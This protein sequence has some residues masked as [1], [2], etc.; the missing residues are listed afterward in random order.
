MTFRT[1]I[2]LTAPVSL[3]LQLYTLPASAQTQ[4][5]S[6]GQAAEQPPIVRFDPQGIGVLEAVMLTLQNDPALKLQ[7]TAVQRAGGLEQ[8]ARGLF[9]PSLLTIA[10]YEYRIQE[11]TENRKE[12][13]R[14]KRENA[15]EQLD[16]NRTNAERGRALVDQLQRVRDSPPGSNQ[17]PLLTQLSPTLGAQVQVIDALIAGTSD[18]AQRATLLDVRNTLLNNSIQQTQSDLA[19]IVEAFDASQRR[20]ENLGEAPIDEVFYSGQLSVQVAKLFRNGISVTP[21]FDGSMQGTN[22]RGKPRSDEF[23]GKGLQDL[24]TFHAGVGIVVPLLQGRGSTAVAARERAAQLDLEASRLALGHERAVSAL[25]AITAY[26]ALRAAQE[27]ADVAARSLALQDRIVAATNARIKAGDMLAV[28]GTRAQATAARARARVEETR[29]QLHEARVRLASAMGVAVTADEATLPLARDPFPAVAVAP[30]AEQSGPLAA[31]ATGSRQ[32]VAAAQRSQEA[33]EVIRAG[34]L[35]NVRSRLDF[36]TSLYYT[37]LEERSIA[38]AI[39]RWVGPSTNGAI[40]YERP[41]GNNRA[42]GIYAQAEA[43]A[44]ERQIAAADVRR[45]TSLGVMRTAGA[46]PDAVARLREAEEG[47]KLATAVVESDIAR[48]QQGDVSIVTALFTEQQAVEAELTRVLARQELAQL[49]AQLRFETGTLVGDGPV[50]VSSLT[51][52]P[53]AK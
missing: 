12:N 31:L 42:R 34:A 13:E 44:R 29:R 9:D 22:F 5:P 20:V 1:R 21:F 53:A 30:A 46:L 25:T 17:V 35:T 3:A 18:P 52:L 16:R 47:V 6:P 45:Q 28:D 8:E 23:G 50:S 4:T 26:W 19:V 39:D 49:I 10:Q 32:D 36:S 2:A 27:S 33:G 48:L 38:R 11:L 15:R 51:T 43:A 41:Y 40:E 24:F 7:E 14:A 37:A